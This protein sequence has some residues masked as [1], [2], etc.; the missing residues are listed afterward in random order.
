MDSKY[1]SPPFL[2][3]NDALS[4]S[5]WMNRYSNVKTAISAK[6]SSGT[7]V[8]AA[9]VNALVEAL[10]QLEADLGAMSNASMEYEIARS[11]LARREVVLD[12]LKKQCSLINT[13]ESSNVP[14]F[15]T[16]SPNSPFSNSAANKKN[17]VQ[18]NPLRAQDK[19][20]GTSDAGLI[21]R[22]KDII[23]QQD[24]AL[25]DILKGTDRLHTQALVI[26]QEARIHNNIISKLDQNVDEATDELKEGTQQAR[27]VTR[28]SKVCGMYLC[29]A[30]QI[31]VIVALVIILFHKS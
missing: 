13:K 17:N 30:A 22:Q 29:I 20:S 8:S 28:K 31:L 23:Q 21:E 27:S 4:A 12:G 6:R 25:A 7:A 24:E 18:M 14:F 9:Q 2:P 3:P 16:P 26:G 5:Q 11:E 15:S 1:L 19:V 10:K